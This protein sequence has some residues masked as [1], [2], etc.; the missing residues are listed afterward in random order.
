MKPANFSYF[1][2]RNAAE[3]IAMLASAGEDARVLAGGQSLVPMMNFR[4]VRPSALVDLADCADLAYARADG[5]KLRIGAMMRQREAQAD[6]VILQHC[7]LVAE[8]LAH[9]GPTTVRNRATVGGTIANGYPV[10]ELPVVAVC[11]DAE[12]V[13]NGP[14]GTRTVPARDFFIVG[15]VTAIETGELLR[16]VVFPARGP[17]TGYGFAESGNHAGGAAQAIAAIGAEADGAGWKDVRI[18]A[19]GLR[20]VPVRLPESEHAVAVG[21]P[22]A[23]AFAADLERLE[24]EE[25]GLEA[26]AGQRRLVQ[27]VV[28][29]A[30]ARLRTV[31]ETAA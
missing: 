25:D 28:E 21:W 29:D 13:L 24:A 7:P 3:A 16:E 14:Q 23:E 31:E 26:D 1:R 22:L 5:G 11:L 30:L 4:I 9:A 8:A 2:P 17:R 20:S 27:I 19:A 18:A 15:M 12:I 10:A 6:A